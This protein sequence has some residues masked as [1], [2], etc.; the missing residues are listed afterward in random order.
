MSTTRLI[1]N[2]LFIAF[3]FIPV[4]FDI[5]DISRSL[6]QNVNVS[7]MKIFGLVLYFLMAIYTSVTLFEK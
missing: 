6:K 2:I 5:R 1:G 4:Y 7:K 3:L